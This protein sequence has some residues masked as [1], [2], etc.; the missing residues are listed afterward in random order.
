MIADLQSFLESVP[1]RVW[2]A[3]AHVWEELWEEHSRELTFALFGVASAVVR[4]L[5]VTI[6]TGS[7]GVLFSFGRARRELQPGF[8][9]LIPFLQVAPRIATRQRTLDLP[10][11]RVTTH[12]GLVYIVD[13][14]LVFR[15]VDATRAVVE[16]D[17]LDR[18]MLQMLGL[19]VQEVLRSLTR[20]RIS[21]GHE[22]DELLKAAAAPRLAPWGVD[23]EK[24]GFT[25]ITPSVKTL[26]VTQ[27]RQTVTE[28]GRMLAL[29]LRRGIAPRRALSLLGARGR[30]LSRTRHLRPLARASR[31]K[32]RVAARLIR[33]GRSHGQIHQATRS[34]ASRLGQVS[35]DARRARETRGSLRKRALQ[36]QT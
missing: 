7:T 22:L 24:A 16:I 5:G 32:H 30:L 15:V 18:G 26:R 20:E 11:Q 35:R 36:A 8:H 23:V 33:R 14:N 29:M 19:S 6:R 13:A 9:L 31:T 4:A 10:A 12:E 21:T 17:D 27:V 3:L 28:R 2:G 34:L 1:G 25:S